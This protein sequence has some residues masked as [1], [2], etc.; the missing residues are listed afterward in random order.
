MVQVKSCV[1]TAERSAGH[2]LGAGG[3]R[4]GGS[5]NFHFLRPALRYQIV[6]IAKTLQLVLSFIF[7]V[8]NLQHR[9]AVEGVSNLG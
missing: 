7:S 6:D 5:S 8:S 3:N 2:C 9:S 4:N 1:E